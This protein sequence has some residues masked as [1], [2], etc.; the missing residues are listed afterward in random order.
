[1]IGVKF[2]RMK[3]NAGE[4]DFIIGIGFET[5]PECTTGTKGRVI[6]YLSVPKNKLPSGVDLYTRELYGV[7]VML[8]KI[9]GKFEDM[10][11]ETSYA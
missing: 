11:N 1:M 4:A 2:I 9:T 10:P 6:R 3:D 5:E 7:P 8:N